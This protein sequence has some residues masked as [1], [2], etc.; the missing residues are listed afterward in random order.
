M[1]AH[2]VL[3]QTYLTLVVSRKH[4]FYDRYRYYKT[5]TRVVDISTHLINSISVSGLLI[6]GTYPN[7]LIVGQWSTILSAILSA[8]KT[9]VSPRTIESEH[10]Y[11]YG[12]YCELERDITLC[13]AEDSPEPVLRVFL[14]ALTKRMQLVEDRD[15]PPVLE[16]RDC[17][18]EESPMIAK[19]VF[20]N[21]QQ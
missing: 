5:L 15:C 21:S 14:Q 6:T 13:M 20:T 8:I 18:P 12:A 17:P 9:T 3:L 10:K 11:A 7:G 4:V 19:E 2:R 16:V 1:S